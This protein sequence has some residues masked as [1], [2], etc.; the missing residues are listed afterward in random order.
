MEIK[1]VSEKKLKSFKKLDLPREILNT[2]AELFLVE[3]KNN[4]NK[5][6]QLFKKLYFDEGEI[7]SNKLYTIN[8]LIDKKDEINLEELVMPSK[9]ITVKGRVAGFTMPYIENIN[10]KTILTSHDFD[11]KYQI[12]LLKEVG[13][14]LEKIKKVRDYS[15]VTD[16]YLNDIHE[17][18]FILNKKTNK[19]NV[20]DLD[21]CK[22]G[23][24]LAQSSKYLAN[25]KPI[26]IKMN[27]YENIDEEEKDYYKYEQNHNKIGGIFTINE[28]TD[29]FCYNIMILNYL[30]GG[31]VAKLNLSEFYLYL[32]YLVDIG[33]PKEMA[34]IFNL[35][36]I[37]KDNKNPYELLDSIEKPVYKSNH[38][39]FKNKLKKRI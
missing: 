11:I 16:F 14:I 20:V 33:L 2:E 35:L 7:F 36:Y 13:E 31:N 37:E 21:S 23:N 12:S 6:L 9:L 27:K 3:D 5:H 4:W 17:S 32:E 22:I 26:L 34:D 19:L 18:N 25:A 39:V 15:K 8:E 30:Y 1:N 24:N 28:N 10:L 38:N 29:L